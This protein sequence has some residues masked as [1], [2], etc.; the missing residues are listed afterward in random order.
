MFN[1]EACFDQQILETKKERPTVV[2]PECLDVRVIGAVSNLTRFVRPVMLA[3]QED[4]VAVVAKDSGGLD[5]DRVTYAFSECVFIDIGQR[6]DL[7]DAY[8]DLLIKRLSELGETID[9]NEAIQRTSNPTWFA[10]LAVLAGHADAVVGGA[11]YGPKD[12]FRPM[13]KLLKD[14]E[15]AIEAGVIVLPDN[16]P[17][18]LF[19]ENI[20]VLGDA[21]VNAVMDAHAL[22]E[23]AVGTC[24]I[25][26]DL[27]P[28]TVLPTIYGAM[29]SY[30][31]RGSDEGQGADL[32]RQAAELLP[33]IMSKR[34]E[35]GERYS[36]IKLQI[37]VKVSAALSERSATYYQDQDF[38]DRPNVL[39][40]PNLDTGNL[41]F[42]LF[43]TQFPEAKKFGSVFGLKFRGMSLAQDCTAED[44]RLTVK[45]NTLRMHKYG[46]WQR[47]P[48]DTFF[49]RYRIL[50]IN[51]GSTS[52]KIAVF[53]GDAE[54]FTQEIQHTP[55]ELAPFEGMPITE[56]FQFRKNTIEQFLASNK[57]SINDLD[58]VAGRGGLLH[59]MPH[60]TF[61]VNDRMVEDLKAGVLGE[62]ASNL[63]G[64]IARDLVG[65]S[66][67][68]AFIVDPVV[69]DESDDRVKIT[70][71]KAIRR[72]VISHA[73]N[74]IATAHK[75]AEECETFYERLNLIVCHMGGGISIG[76]HKKGRYIDANDALDGE[77]PFTPQRSGSL[78]VGEFMKLVL[79]GKYTQTELKQLI[80]GK[81]GLI[82]LLGTSN[83]IELGKRYESGD[84]HVRSILD[85]QAYQIAKWISSMLPAFDGERVDQIL[86]TGGMARAKFLV[87]E[88]R[89]LL[90]S[91]GCEIT[92]YPGENEM[93][94][95]AKGALRVL[96]GKEAAKAYV[97]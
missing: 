20:L 90:Q 76:A 23:V 55:E 10:I 7:V 75:Y 48:V 84:K 58:A 19:P 5:R 43:S 26:R 11:V 69:V 47:T 49:K 8:A 71:I 13:I 42:H 52:T 33:E 91:F 96:S 27:F 77:G 53:E 24:A 35:K 37:G 64:L 67:K 95:L 28:E 30:S 78:P 93:A 89:R 46:D 81:G 62:H 2:F 34:I 94:A 6:R 60:G 70:G 68:P 54:Q 45:A 16:H 15:I 74:Q 9:R 85:A 18:S 86:L 66:G 25:A 79:S 97:I 72:K 4:V 39:I 51:P 87:A 44:I 22:A 32:V 88:I 59:P 56:Q 61:Y 38:E 41:L 17:Q 92:V 50:S 65:N 36:K 83:L 12:F 1:I 3:S 29:V 57:I 14:R 82:D 80:K 40:C 21:G 31:H 73:L 63:G